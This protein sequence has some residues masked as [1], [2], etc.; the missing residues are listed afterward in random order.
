MSGK[1]NILICPLEWGLGHA[2]RMI[3]LAQKLVERN[4]NV[5]FAAGD[6]HL[7]F[8]RNEM[9]GLTYIHFPGFR[10]FYSGF[11]PQYFMLLLT[12]PILIYHSVAEHLKLKEIITEYKIDIIISDNRFGLWN[13]KIPSVYVTHQPRIPFPRSLAFL[14]F[15]GIWI[16]RMIIRKYTYC[17]LPDLPG[18][19]NL[20]G[21]LTHGIK[22]PGNVRF[23]GI[24]SRFTDNPLNPEKL[25]P[26]KNLIAVILSGPEPQ[27]SILEKKVK[28]MLIRNDSQA[29]I[30]GG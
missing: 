5:I 26:A 8:L 13:R 4:H 22:L 14:E 21:R 2:G 24:L 6:D 1:K 17:F 25:P 30:F 19:I 23:I 7:A 29:V 16:H 12:L 10:P 28:E 18:I 15:T 9:P 27:R 3:A 11:L 20:T